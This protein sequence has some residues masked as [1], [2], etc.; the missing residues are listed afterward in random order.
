MKAGKAVRSS[1]TIAGMLKIFDKARESII[2]SI[3]L[4]KEKSCPT[5]SIVVSSTSPETVVLER[6][7]YRTFTLMRLN[8]C[9]YN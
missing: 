9:L 4:Y 2:Q 7:G 6:N 8:Q 1:I 3:K 5:T